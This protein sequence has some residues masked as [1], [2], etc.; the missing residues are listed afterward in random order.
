MNNYILTC[1]LLFLG[2]SM[3]A[4]PQDSS[5]LTAVD[6]P[7]LFDGCDDPLISEEQRQAC[8][9]P[10]IQAFINEN[11]VYPD[12]ARARNIEGVVVVRF[13]VTKE[14]KITDLEL[15]RNI[16]AGC[17]QEAM[18]VIRMMPDFRPALRNGEPVATKMTLPIRFKRADEAVSS[19][20]N[21]YQIHWG[22]IYQDKVTKEALKALLKRYFLVRD[23]YGNTYD[24][25]FLTLKIDAKGK[26]I[27]LETRG[28][29]LNREMLRA[30]KKMRAGQVVAI[31]AMIQKEYQDIEVVRTLE[32]VK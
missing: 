10:K 22:T 24:V 26:E 31:H 18:R 20:K 15:V 9:V 32:I 27:V 23:Y 12:S 16:G 25:R 4:Q 29:T 21:L 8:S 2:L 7:P 6:I 28:N 1:F 19:N 17:G 3:V 5:I 13:S 14:G 30:L 11:I